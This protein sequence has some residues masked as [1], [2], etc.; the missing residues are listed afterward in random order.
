[1]TKTADQYLKINPWVVIE[2]GFHPDK[3][4][5]SESIFSLGNEF[6]GVRGY[7][8]E[9]YS[10]DSLIGSYFNGVYEETEI[11]HPQYFKGLAT[12]SCFMVNAVNW[13]FTRIHLD[14]DVL[15]LHH[16]QITEYNRRLDLKIGS[17]E[18]TLV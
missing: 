6:M 9:G 13:L 7:L 18:R 5:V 4:R 12:R 8:E 3:S 16:S 17:L 11:C 10:G 1:M 2:E 14:G 15:N